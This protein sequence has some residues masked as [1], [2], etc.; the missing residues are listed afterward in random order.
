[1][2]YPRPPSDGD[3]VDSYLRDLGRR[4]EFQELS[5][6]K[7][8]AKKKGKAVATSLGLIQPRAYL[9]A[10]RTHGYDPA[11]GDVP[12]IEELHLHAMQAFV[13]RFM[14]PDS[15]NRRLLLLWDTGTGKTIAAITIGQRYAQ[16]YRSLKLLPAGERPTVFV[17]GFTRSVIQ[18]EMLRDP[19]H[20]FITQGE[21]AELRRFRAAAQGK[22]AGSPE[23]RKYNGYLGT[24]RRLLTD[25][26]RGGYYQFYGYKE[27]ASQLLVVTAKGVEAGVR[28]ID[29][30]TRPHT[31]QEGEEVDVALSEEEAEREVSQMELFVR[32]IADAEE[33]GLMKVNTD[34][35]KQLRH[36]LIIADE[37]HNVYNVNDPNMYGVAIQYVLDAFPID[38]AP[39][40][41]FMSAT[42]LSGSPA[43][44]V[45]LLNLLV[46]RDE[47]PQRRPL[48]RSDFFTKTGADD[49]AEL[50]HKPGAL[51][52]ISR[53]ATGHVTFLTVA[54]EDHSSG[55]KLFPD[56]IFEGVSV[57]RLLSGRQSDED[58]PYLKFV[59]YK[60][61]KLQR[62]AL[63]D[64]DQR[65][66]GLH[67]SQVL[68]TPPEYALYDMVFPNPE[69][70]DSP[71]VPLYVST[72]TDPIY[73]VMARASPEWRD[74]VGVKILPESVAGGR[75]APVLSGSYLAMPALAEYS[76]K[77]AQ[78]VTDLKDFVGSNRGKALV[79]HDRVQLTGVSI[80]GEILAHNGFV[81]EGS[82]ITAS[83]ICNVCGETQNRHKK[84]AKHEFAPA[85]YAV[86]TGVMD[87]A[88]RE[89]VL[90]KFNLTTNLYGEEI[91][92]LIGSRVLVE[93]LDF[94]PIRLQCLLSIPRNIPTLIQILGRSRR[95]GKHLMLP[96]EE[97]SVMVRIYLTTDEVKA[98]RPPGEEM[99]LR[100]PDYIKISRKMSRFLLIQEEARA[101][102]TT[103]VNGFLPQSQIAAEAKASLYGLPFQL[104]VPFSSL[105]DEPVTSETYYAYNG[106]EQDIR[107]IIQATRLL[108]QRRPVWP[109]DELI[110]ALRQPGIIGNQTLNPAY[111]GDALVLLALDRLT[112]PTLQAKSRHSGLDC[113][114]MLVSAHM[115]DAAGQLRRI[116]Q[117]EPETPDGPSYYIAAPLDLQGRPQ[118]DVESY[119]RRADHSSALLQKP[120]R[121]DLRAYV[122]SH[123]QETNFARQLE[124]FEEKYASASDVRSIL[125][126]Y[127]AAFHF[128]LLNKIVLDTYYGRELTPAVAGAAKVY[129]RFRVLVTLGQLGCAQG[130]GEMA[131]LAESSRRGGR[132]P[133]PDKST[134]VGYIKFGG[135]RVLIE[136]PLNC[137][138]TCPGV[139]QMVPLSALGIETSRPENSVMVGYTEVRGTQLRFKIREPLQVLEKTKVRDV[140]SLSKGAV[141]ET[142]SR[143]S[144]LQIARKLTQKSMSSLKELS[145]SHL[146]G[147]IRNSLLQEEE[148]ARSTRAGMKTGTRWFYLFNETLPT[149]RAGRA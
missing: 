103:A 74:R 55:A 85:R 24:M 100:A 127:D 124:I 3:S 75:N 80:L 15:P 148:G 143:E 21:L 22:P 12:K 113:D 140:R 149:I 23:S 131:S 84:G 58:I 99:I 46:P 137:E 13:D 69:A 108:F 125:Y 77:Y 56:Q 63:K 19:N 59:P 86:V 112:R 106:A 97:R 138:G 123:L 110:A 61:S 88:S 51:E 73:N 34:L 27:F 48:R 11:E 17:I 9:A 42:P 53:L 95:R 93:G 79:Y 90:A 121:I 26:A 96:P 133:K 146:C 116:V 98:G 71:G 20:G 102:R 141:C 18:A 81:A 39:R 91:R 136:A 115:R 117:C 50:A 67:R 68:P 111:Y 104:P 101:L 43:E 40:A 66:S 25:R 6:P 128:G 16:L 126:R 139:W 135:G 109:R 144:Q 129:A 8:A 65:K 70:S 4:R 5:E 142:R 94:E 147:L 107:R 35:L 83:A 38:E 52:M 78:F 29:L 1:M 114:Q 145:S 62:A 44:V 32:R 105:K 130:F 54:M 64:W 49:S 41:V 28:A 31:T 118:L 45:D 47:L 92:V 10:P 72:T 2:A 89:R 119:L 120:V 33:K 82:P 14:H 30:F 87:A 134:I 7:G 76:G 36:G 122:A 37:I 60:L 132:G 57:P